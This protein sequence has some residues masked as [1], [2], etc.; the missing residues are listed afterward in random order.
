MHIG[1]QA[2]P[3]MVLISLSWND[4][5]SECVILVLSNLSRFKTWNSHKLKHRG[6]PIHIPNKV[7]CDYRISLGV[8]NGSV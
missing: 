1:T 3:L 7:Q 6:I 2:E 5:N 4:Q 8:E